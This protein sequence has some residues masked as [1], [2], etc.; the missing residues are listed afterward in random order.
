MASGTSPGDGPGDLRLDEQAALRRVATAV[1]QQRT[2]DEIFAVVT[3]EAGPLFGATASTLF[4]FE[5]AVGVAV[6][7]WHTRDALGVPKGLRVDL[8][9]ES[10]TGR[11]Y[12]TG[13]PARVD[14]YDEIEV[15]RIDGPLRALGIHA[16]VA[17]PIVVDGRVWGSISL[18]TV[19]DRPFP[20]ST[21]LRLG[22]FAELVGQAVANA[23][24]RRELTESRVR[25]V[26][27]ADAARRRIERDLHDGA[28]QRLVSL[29]LR[30]Q[31]ARRT[32]GDPDATIAALDACSVELATALEE[33]RELARG[34]HPAMLTER[35]LGA[36]LQFVADRAPLPVDLNVQLDVRLAPAHEA[37]LYF[38]ACEA[39]ANVTKHAEASAVSIRAWRDDG[40]IVIEIADDGV[41][42]AEPMRGSGLRG[43]TDRLEAVG[44]Q[45]DVTSAPGHGTTVIATV[46]ALAPA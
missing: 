28:Q 8:A 44:G 17:A 42:G 31:L 19:S 24:A 27:A 9:L 13:A 4:R 41:G 20:P 12:Q 26:E 45:L 2:P 18:S 39:L 37:A 15:E 46:P 6:S 7:D 22:A 1:A 34:I 23:E 35:G 29:A 36:A 25:I 38:T 33:L 40:R 11:V 30:L 5:G 10:A 32:A 16:A 21:E 3:D 14:S 43:L